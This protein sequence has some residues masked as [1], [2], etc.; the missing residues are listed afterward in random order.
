[1]PKELAGALDRDEHA[2]YELI[3]MRTIASQMADARGQT[4]SV[5]IGAKTSA[6]EDAELGA[7]GTVIAFRGFLAA[8]EEGRDDESAAVDETRLPPLEQGQSLDV[9]GLEAQGHETSPPARFTEATLVQALEERGIGRPS[10]YAAIIAV[11]LDRGYVFKKGTALVPT[12][13]AFAVTQLLEQHFASLVDYEFTA[14]MEDDL[15]RIASGEEERVAWLTRFYNGDGDEPGL[16]KLVTEHLDEIDAR[17]VNSI[18]IP[19]SDIVVRVGKYGPFLKRG[20]ESASLPDE[21]VPDELTPA[22]AEELLSQSSSERPLGSHPDTG[23]SIVLRHGRYGPYV[24]EE[25]PDETDAKPRTASLFASMDAA[26]VTLDDAVRLLSLPRTVGADPAD[27]GEI[28]AT[29]G[30]YGPF[31]KKGSETRSLENEEQLFTL[32]LEDALAL[33]AQPKRGRARTAATPLREI[34]PDPRTE[35]PIVIKD[36]RFGPY[37][38]DGETNAS[39]RSGDSVESLT[40]ERAVELLAERRSRGPAKK[41]ATRKTK[42][43]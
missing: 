22:K 12:F 6:G 43:S 7:T 3:W 21:V 36:G 17:A 32:T 42:K 41:R 5:R 4:V 25:L 23:R 29:N 38:T 27:G 13:T 16:H 1:M 8:Y 18:A 10:T 31:I 9:L 28:V 26:T 37:V 20:D 39:L 24:T 35:K 34:G 30:R 15:D 14:R 40:I 19:G 33:L 2:L 11:I